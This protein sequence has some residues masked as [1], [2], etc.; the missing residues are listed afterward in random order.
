MTQPFVRG[1]RFLLYRG[2]RDKP[3]QPRDETDVLRPP[4]IHDIL[5]GRAGALVPTSRP[6]RILMTSYRSAPLTGGQGVYLR[7]MTRALA[8]RG[9]TVD[10]I[11][12]PPYPELDPRVHLIKLPS[13]DLYAR[14]I[15]RFGVPAL[16]WRE[17]RAPIDL[18]EYLLHVCGRFGEPYTFGERLARYMKRHLDEYDI[19]H[20]NQTFAHGLARLQAM[21]CRVVGTIHHPITKD[22]ELALAAAEDWKLR[23]LIRQWY[24]FL[25]MQMKVARTIDPIMVIS[26]RA[27][28]DAAESFGLPLERLHR[29]YLGIDTDTFAPAPGLPRHERRLI[30]TVSADV[31]LKGLSHLIGAV[32]RLVPRYPDLDLTLVG[33]LREGPARRLIEEHGLAPRIRCV[34][35][36]TDSELAREYSSATI[37][38]CPSLYEG[39]GLPT[40]EAMACETPVVATRAGALPELVGDAGVLVRPGCADA[41]AT[42]IVE[43][44]EDPERRAELG[45]R[46]RQRILRD[47]TWAKTAQRAE[48][49]YA[50]A[51]NPC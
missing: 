9:H 27:R 47:F 13:L 4:P 40:G 15:S 19:I 34:S 32:A 31:P 48:A 24:G 36:L 18:M 2:S 51:L 33:T 22:L 45:R 44:F 38:V 1:R 16:P 12:G 14:K 10:V 20:D 8:D 49:I 26:E 21:G 11:S 29:V 30:A 25:R 7:H 28:H 42:A 50:Q 17:L 41:L 5:P 35:G 3:L 37:A 39:F 43:L 6:L 46:A 23:S